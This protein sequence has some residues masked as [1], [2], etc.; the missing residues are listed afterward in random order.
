MKKLILIL[1]IA[2]IANP[3]FAQ[4]IVRV[5][6]R[7]GQEVNP[8]ADNRWPVSHLNAGVAGVKMILSAPGNTKSHYVTGFMMGGAKDPNGFYLLRQ[9]CVLLNAAADNIA[10]TE[11]GTTFDWDTKTNN[12]DFSLE[13]WINY[14]A[15]T[16]AAPA[17]VKT[18]DETN[19]GWL[20]ETS[21][22]SLLTFT[23]DDGTND[24]TI[25]GATAIDD[26]AWH[27]IVVSVDRSSDTG[28]NLY[29]DGELDATAVDPTGVANAVNPGANIVVTGVN[30]EEIYISALG[31]WLD[32]DGFL[33]AS[34]VTSRYNS[35]IGLKYEGDETGLL[36][37]YNMDEGIGSSCYDI[38]N[39]T[40]NIIALTGTPWVPS[41]QNGATAEVNEAGV[42]FNSRDM[43]RAVGKFECAGAA[44]GQVGATVFIKFPHPIKIGRNCPLNILET[45]GGFNLMVFGY[46]GPN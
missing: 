7:M 1:L 42:P 17:L 28:L 33:S 8:G 14:E 21:A 45:I 15:T 38:K 22:A 40:G 29:V 26:G 31:I 5:Y 20:L 9:N 10:L 24:A 34:E 39:A 2:M 43:M 6:D 19:N 11:D 32:A 12:G 46:T 4:E 37:G 36:V 16:A 41:R 23:F 35:G 30:S 3:I 13:L 25:T 18:G 44:R 27:H